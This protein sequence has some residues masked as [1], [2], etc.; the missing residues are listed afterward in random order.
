MTL[1]LSAVQFPHPGSEHKPGPGDSGRMGWNAGQHK[2]KFLEAPGRW[3]TDDSDGSGLLRFWGE[4]EPPSDWEQLPEPQDKR[5]PRYLHRPVIA[6]APSGRH[7]NTDP[8][9]VD[10]FWYSNCRQQQFK[11]LPSPTKMTR[12]DIGSVVLF[13]SKLNGEW[14]LDTVFV[15]AD[16]EGLRPVDVEDLAA[17]R[18]VLGYAVARPLYSGDRERRDFVL[19]RGATADAPVDDRFSFVPAVPAEQ[20]SFA[21][22]ALHL[23]ALNPNLAMATRVVAEG[24]EVHSVWEHARRRVLD[25]GLVL[26]T[27]M[28]GPGSAATPVSS[29]GS[30]VDQ[31]RGGY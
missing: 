6:D 12:L 31:D 27:F 2:R 20:G 17:D 18:P 14:V 5:L 19:Y 30:T 23:E 1:T 13:G 7:Q 28:D 3:I 16:R 25:A 15:V 24:G 11:H 21:R 9:V 4:W 10:G 26:G 8:L 29:T 22:P